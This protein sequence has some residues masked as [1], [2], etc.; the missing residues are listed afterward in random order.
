MKLRKEW[1][2]E[3]LAVPYEIHNFEV[4]DKKEGWT[5][6]LYLRELQFEAEDFAKLWLAPVIDDSY[7][8]KR[9]HYNY[10]S[11]IIEDIDWHCGCT[12]YDK[13]GGIDGD[14][15]AVKVGCDYQHYWDEGHYYN[16]HILEQDAK[17]A[18]DSLYKVFPKIKSWCCWCGA[19]GY[20]FI[21]NEEKS[22][23]RCPPCDEKRKKELELKVATPAKEN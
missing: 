9:I 11:S 6:Y 10:M 15:R 23:W 8:K 17:N 13:L 7:G 4:Y 1:N 18:I 14:K 12:F 2:G 16:E 5:F 22:Y 3:Y 19:W 21:P 20:N